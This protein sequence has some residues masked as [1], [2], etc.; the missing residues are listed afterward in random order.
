[1]ETHN[2]GTSHEYGIAMP[3]WAGT[4]WF[5]VM[6]HGGVG[7]GEVQQGGVPILQHS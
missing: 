5:Y 3:S 1:M 6:K 7:P 4:Y 2:Y